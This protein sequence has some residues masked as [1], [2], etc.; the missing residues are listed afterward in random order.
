[1]CLSDEVN[2]PLEPLLLVY[3]LD[4]IVAIC[5]L[6]GN[7]SQTRSWTCRY[8]LTAISLGRPL[9]TQAAPRPQPCQCGLEEGLQDLGACTRPE[10]MRWGVCKLKA[11]DFRTCPFT[12]DALLRHAHILIDF[13]HQL[14]RPFRCYICDFCDERWE[15]RWQVFAGHGFSHC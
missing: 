8:F 3:T 7:N 11:Q 9:G 13:M 14:W 1:M 10:C 4:V 15:L 12:R 6:V 2:G 5:V